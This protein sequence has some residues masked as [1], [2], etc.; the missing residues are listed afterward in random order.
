MI[1][2]PLADRLEYA[3]LETIVKIMEGR[4]QDSWGGWTAQV[5]SRGVGQSEFTQQ[6][7]LSAFKRLWKQGLLRLTK[8]DSQRREANEY[9]ANA[10]DDGN[11][12]FTSTFNADITDEG[13]R[14]WDS[15]REEPR[16]PIGFSK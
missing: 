10:A 15:I 16:R 3:I 5:T 2:G 7:L 1:K 13:R 8:P 9:S 14:Y 11:F 4:Q 12:F 6:D